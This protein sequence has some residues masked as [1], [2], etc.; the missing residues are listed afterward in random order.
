LDLDQIASRFKIRT[1]K[2]KFSFIK[3]SQEK[4]VVKP[5]TNI[6]QSNLK[7]LTSFKYALGHKFKL[8]FL[9]LICLTDFRNSKHLKILKKVELYLKK[10]FSVEFIVQKLNEI[11]K[12]KFVCFTPFEM[13][14]MRM[15][16]NPAIEHNE[17]VD[18]NLIQ[19]LWK[20]YEFEAEIIKE[21]YDELKNYS[22]EEKELSPIVDRILKL[23]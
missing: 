18:M 1:L 3:F 22:K 17:E 14:L 19:N 21:D 11:D 6:P 7:T 20:K 2:R 12:I 10:K 8:K 4:D 16:Q 5:K 15:I 13:N 9:D 23:I